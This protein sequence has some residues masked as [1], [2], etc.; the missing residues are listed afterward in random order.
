MNL[1]EFFDMLAPQWEEKLEEEDFERIKRLIDEI[2]IRN[3]NV[4]DC[5]CGTGILHQFLLEKL[6]PKGKIFEMDISFNML[7]IAKIKNPKFI[8][9]GDAEF[10]P[11]ISSSFDT[12]I[13]LNAFP[14]FRN[15]KVVLKET[16]RILKDGGKLFILHTFPREE[17]NSFH[18]NYGG[19]IAD[20]LLPENPEIISMLEEANF[21][22]IKIIEKDVFIVSAEKI[23]E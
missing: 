3:G 11:F 7:K 22:K 18:K 15:K 10:M 12:V 19:I 16:F 20:D 5:G 6:G 23:G 21:S 2:E 9:Q 17:V 8:L 13:F 1:R 14:H 4:L